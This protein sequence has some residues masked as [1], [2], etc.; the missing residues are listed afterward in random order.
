MAIDIV[1]VAGLFMEVLP[2][3]LVGCLG[4]LVRALYG[5]VKA[6]NNGFSFDA[7]YFFITV[8]SAGFIG[9]IIGFVFSSDIRVSALSGYV[10]T[11]VLENVFSSIAPKVLVVKRGE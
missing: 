11:D 6:A 10:G 9:S 2:F 5:T 8:V 4:G 7:Y 3:V 1:A